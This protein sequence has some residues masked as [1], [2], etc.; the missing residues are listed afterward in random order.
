MA[1]LGVNFK[2]KGSFFGELRDAVKSAFGKKVQKNFG[3]FRPTVEE[4]I[5]EGVIN[6]RNEFIP[7][8]DEAAQLGVGQ[9]GSIDRGRT[10]GAWS[11]LL[12]SSSNG[13]VTFSVRKDSRK[14]KIGKITVNIDE[15]AFFR[16][17]LSNI[18]TESEH[19]PN[20][21]WMEWLIEGAPNGS[22]L[23]DYEFS[24]EVPQSSKSRTGAGR[25]ITVKGGIWRFP[26]ARQGA[27]KML[28]SEVERQIEIA[29]R[30]DIGKVL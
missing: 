24:G 14:N 21:P 2:V 18:D 23:P 3:A 30:R 15:E 5:D 13:I 4:A 10:R 7:N 22:V 1:K 9:G 20:I 19:L 8:D 28:G 27:F 25:M 26:P 12:A 29:I 17:S 16:A 11:Q 6:R